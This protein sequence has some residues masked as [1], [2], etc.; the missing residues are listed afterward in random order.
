MS[1]ELWT[2]IWWNTNTNYQEYL[3]SRYLTTYTLSNLKIL[4]II[5]YF[6]VIN[7]IIYQSK[8]YFCTLTLSKYFYEYSSLNMK[9]KMYVIVKKIKISKLLR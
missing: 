3:E 4:N 8:F 2:N 6:Y 5:L 7:I 1:D 9:L